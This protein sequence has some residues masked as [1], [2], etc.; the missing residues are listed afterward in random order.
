MPIKRKS[1]AAGTS[2]EDLTIPELKDKIK[3]L[4]FDCGVRRPFYGPSIDSPQQLRL[5]KD[6][7][8]VYKDALQGKGDKLEETAEEEKPAPKKGAEKKAPA[9]K[10]TKETKKPAAKKAEPKKVQKQEEEEEEEEETP[11]EAP[12]KKKAKKEESQTTKAKKDQR[13]EINGDAPMEVEEKRPTRAAK[14]TKAAPK[15]DDEEEE[16]E[17]EQEDDEADQDESIQSNIYHHT[18]AKKSNPTSMTGE[19]GLQ[20][21]Q[22][23]SLLILDSDEIKGSKKIIGFD[24]DSTLIETKNPKT[25]RGF[26]TGRKDWVWLYGQKVVDKLKEDHEKGYKIVIFTNQAGIKKGNTKREHIEG[27][28]IDLSEEL[29]FPIQAFA[30]STEDIFRKPNATMW[31]YMIKHHNQGIV[32]DLSKCKYV[33]DAAGRPK[34]G[35]K[36]KDFSCGDRAFAHNIG[37]T[38]ETPEQY[39]LGEGADENFD[40]GSEEPQEIIDRYEGKA[41][42]TEKDLGITGEQELVVLVGRPASGKST[43]AKRYFVPKGYVWANNDKFKGNSKK[44]IQLAKASLA[45]GKSVVV[46]NTNPSTTKRAELIELA[47]DIPVRCFYIDTPKD[48]VE[49]MNLYR[50]RVAS[51]RRI[52]DVA[53]RMYEKSFEEPT[54]EEGFT[55]VTKIDFFPQ[56][57]TEEHK[58]LFLQRT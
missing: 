39:F 11:A 12:K 35:S 36:K 7:I 52:P 47:G 49:H 16:G 5:K 27:K 46:D 14:Q 30:A 1:E 40:W 37:I 2:A 9:S 4:G 38:F 18:L 6:L 17:E 34:R 42:P 51:V 45:E 44:V 50:E 48:I 55:S 25:N 15:E 28:I 32:P 24:M 21:R 43:F 54:K 19:N 20:W 31:D 57:P 56:F 58:R 53:Y 13:D 29:G 3:E 10:S 23:K 8:K 41:E 22:L 26:P 33:G